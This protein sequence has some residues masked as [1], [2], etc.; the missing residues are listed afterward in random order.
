MNNTLV[1]TIVG[2]LVIAIAAVFFFF[3][4]T[5]SGV[6]K[7]Q[8]GYTITAEFEAVDG[9]NVGSDIRMAGIKI[10]SVVSQ[11]LNPE[12]FQAIVK[13]AIED[14]VKLPDDSTAKV[15]SDG[16]LG[17]K[18]ISIDPGGSET[19]LKEGDLLTYTQGSIDLWGMVNQFL[20]SNKEKE[21]P[22]Q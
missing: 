16:L 14:S 6:G 11:Q 22:A 13:M 12:S 9:I 5:T 18:F 1:E 4:Y 3:A 15:T 19:K 17:S 7:G 21:K 20:F 2:A 8:G 10:G